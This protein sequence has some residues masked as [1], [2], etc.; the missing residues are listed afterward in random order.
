M[1]TI[2]EAAAYTLQFINQTQRSVFLTGKAG[3]GKTTLLKEIIA[4]H[5]K[6]LLSWRLRNSGIKRRR[7]YHSFYVSVAFG[8][9]IPSFNVDSQFTVKFESKDTCVGILK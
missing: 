7:C 8:G 2:S 9:F 4:T 3:T 1:Q 5:I 6:I